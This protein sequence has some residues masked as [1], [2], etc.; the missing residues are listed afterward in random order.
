MVVWLFYF[1]AQIARSFSYDNKSRL[2][3]YK[4]SYRVKVSYKLGNEFLKQL[5][6]RPPSFHQ[7]FYQMLPHWNNW[8]IILS[9]FVGGT[10]ISNNLIRKITSIGS[11]GLIGA[12]FLEHII[13]DGFQKVT[14]ITRRKIPHLQNKD[15]TIKSIH[16]FSYNNFTKFPLFNPRWMTIQW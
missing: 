3:E 5:L 9:S 8:I 1:T 14:A 10:K 2:R 12:Y 4:F 11:T 6:I 15:F 16:N 13:T 7:P